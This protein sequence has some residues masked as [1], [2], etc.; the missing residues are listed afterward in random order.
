MLVIAR[1]RNGRRRN[2]L[3]NACQLGSGKLHL[4]CC[5]RFRQ[6]LTRTGAD[7]GNDTLSL[8][9]Y[10]GD[11]QLCRLETFFSGKSLQLFGKLFI[12]AEIIAT[13]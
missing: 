3:F 11:R 1:S 4:K 13:E 12:L 7:H 5:Q 10:P 2:I 8:G 9:E 6:L